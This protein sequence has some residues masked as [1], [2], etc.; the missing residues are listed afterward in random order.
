MGRQSPNIEQRCRK[1]DGCVR[2]RTC[3]SYF[4]HYHLCT[5]LS[6]ARHSRYILD[7]SVRYPK[8]LRPHNPI[9][10]PQ[11]PYIIQ[12]FLTTWKQKQGISW[13]GW[14]SL[15]V[16]E[17][18]VRW[19]AHWSRLLWIVTVHVDYFIC[20]VFSHI[21]LIYF[22]LL[23]KNHVTSSFASILNSLLNTAT[24]RL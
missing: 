14:K 17:K 16:R 2:I 11:N 12:I 5:L 8:L 23:A 4:G 20:R 18:P 3:L 24:T 7:S 1:S 21:L 9:V 22:A 10:S 6:D 19:R 15:S 13:S